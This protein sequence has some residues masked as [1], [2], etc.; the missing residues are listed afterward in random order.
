ME[1]ILASIE[2]RFDIPSRVRAGV[3]RRAARVF[4]RLRRPLELTV[5]AVAIGFVSGIFMP[6]RRKRAKEK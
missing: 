6:H 4:K 5:A 1:D 3:G 2:H